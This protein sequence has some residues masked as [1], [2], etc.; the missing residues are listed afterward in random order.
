MALQ[1]QFIR[2]FPFE[3]LKD[4]LSADDLRATIGEISSRRTA[5]FIGMCGA[6]PATPPSRAAL[7][8]VARA[9]VDA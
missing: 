3:R 1:A 5:R 8:T 9:G 2:I 6:W 4:R 7:P